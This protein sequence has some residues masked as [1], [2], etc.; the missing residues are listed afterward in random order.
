M[1][2]TMFSSN[3]GYCI[4]SVETFKKLKN[5]EMRWI[6]MAKLDFFAVVFVCSELQRIKWEEN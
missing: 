1:S 5:L 4:S 2:K 6:E 3:E